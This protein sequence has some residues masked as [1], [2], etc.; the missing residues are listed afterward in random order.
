MIKLMV[1]DDEPIIRSGIRYSIPWHELDVEVVAEAGNGL[2]AA[3]KAIAVQPDILITDIR[4]PMMDGLDLIRHVRDRLP[5]THFIL[6]SGYSDVEYL[7][8]AISMGVQEYVFKNANY[9]EIV[10]AVQK[11]IVL[12]EKEREVRSR[13]I[14]RDNLLDENL[15]VIR[16][17]LM[18]QLLSGG[19]PGLQDRLRELNIS[20]H[21]PK[22]CLMALP[23]AAVQRWQLVSRLHELLAGYIPFI[24]YGDGI[25]T[26][27]LNL[28]PGTDL[29]SR[30]GGLKN[31]LQ[32]VGV[33]PMAVVCS[34]L[35]DTTHDLSNARTLVYE[36]LD[37]LFWFSGQPLLIAD[38]PISIPIQRADLFA[39][40]GRCIAAFVSKSSLRMQSDLKC[41]F[42]FLQKHCLPRK[43]FL[44]SVTR[45]LVSISAFEQ[46]EDI[47]RFMDEIEQMGYQE[48]FD[49][50]GERIWLGSQH[51]DSRRDL[52][53]Q[54]KDYIA[55]HLTE[56]LTLESVAGSMY[57]SPGYLSRLFKEKNFVGFKEYVQECRLN[58][59]K[60]LLANPSLKTYE[61]ATLSGFRDYKHFSQTFLKCC[62]CSAREYRKRLRPSG[63]S[64]S[65]A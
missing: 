4:M 22:Y 46:N 51:A 45:L 59:A 34:P 52:A 3:E 29:S 24:T 12:I 55:S 27:V 9:E 57:I 37:A 21:G 60:E 33:T 6:L 30:F 8:Q 14:R 49:R 19:A 26:V 17:T 50:I 41:Y 31:E 20:L 11:V 10:T 65:E 13:S 40:E 5:Y 54:A 48:I 64:H 7:K 61:I 47:L 15:T 42:S 53:D 35:L 63:D 1:V 23:C 2:D 38:H 43:D 62:G 44:A 36:A 28:P 58:R 16:A 39:L 18:Q 32:S 56:S 25:V